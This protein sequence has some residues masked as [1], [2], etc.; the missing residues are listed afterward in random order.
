MIVLGRDN[1]HAIA[2]LDRRTQGA[3]RFRCVP[4]IIILVVRRHFVQREDVERS[5]GCKGVP[6]AAKHRS[7]VGGAAQAAG[8]AEKAEGLGH[9]GASSEWLGLA[10]PHMIPYRMAFKVP[11]ERAG[12]IT[13]S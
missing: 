11:A 6:K 3:H 13:K 4:A 2:R 10:K 7:A 5:P 8:E 9:R 12:G 1:N